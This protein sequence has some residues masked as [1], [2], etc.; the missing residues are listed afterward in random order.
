MGKKPRKGQDMQDK[1]SLPRSLI[2]VDDSVL[3]VIDVQDSFLRKL[4]L[5]ELEPLVNRICWLMRVATRLNVPTV[6]TAEDIPKL[7]GVVPVIAEAMAPESLV[8]NKMV[9]G[10][11]ED[12]DIAAVVEDTGRNTAV[13]V[14]L[15]TDVCVAHSALGLLRHGFEVVV[16]GDATSSPGSGH[17]VGLERMR[18]AGVLVSSVKSLYYEW[19]RTVDRD[20]DFMD[21]YGAEIGLPE[22]V[23]L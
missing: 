14:G 2:D 7:G 12:Q 8:L 6:V 18:R 22:G 11:A 3:I 9:F 10:L 19:V 23:S 17:E 16:V 1:I 21:K 13:L 20:N 5:D 4:P 15:E